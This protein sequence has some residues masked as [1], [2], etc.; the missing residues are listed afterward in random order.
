MT[1]VE[2]IARVTHEA[3][4]AYQIATLDPAVSP[5]WEDAPLWQQDSAV[6]G[7]R[8][9]LEGESPEQLHASWCA[10]KVADGWTYGPVKDAALK[11]HPCLVPYADLPREQ[12]LKDDLFVAIVDVLKDA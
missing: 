3:N 9:A 5:H 2:D 12:K 7:V 10:F 6:E 4:R 8:K 1:A 11:T